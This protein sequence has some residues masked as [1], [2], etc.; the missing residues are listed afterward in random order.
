M[1]PIKLPSVEEARGII[2][3]EFEF[4]CQ[5]RDIDRATEESGK[6]STQPAEQD[7][8][9]DDDDNMF[10][11][12]NEM[13]TVSEI[14]KNELER[15]L[16][17]ERLA[18]KKKDADGTVQKKVDILK[19]WREKAASNQY[20]ILCEMA[21][22][23]LAV[24]ASSGEVERL[25]SAGGVIKRRRRNRL[26]IKRVENLLLIKDHYSKLFSKQK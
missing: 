3:D 4:H 20:P 10:S 19:Y 6:S 16:E 1:G 15:Y 24:P 22:I 9:D 26:K 25:F 7:S 17:E 8:D 11:I 2:K 14:V 21:R 12:I 18:V 23:Y 13:P 5:R